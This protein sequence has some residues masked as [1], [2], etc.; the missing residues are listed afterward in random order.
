MWQVDSKNITNYNSSKGELQATILFWVL[1]AGKTAKSAELILSN[2]L[3][4]RDL[5]FEQLKKYSQVKLTNKLKSVGCGCYNSKS[6]TIFELVHSGLDLSKCETEELEKIYGIGKK[7]S[8]GFILHSRK[9]A[10]YAVLDTHILKFLKESGT[11]DVPKSTPASQF[12]Y[13]RLEKAFLSL[14]RKKGVSPAKYDLTIWK[15][16]AN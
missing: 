11:P 10:R 2:L 12:E 3:E 1:A 9:N 6:R 8:R 4:K 14:C 13:I 5:P 16:Y 7:T 15:S